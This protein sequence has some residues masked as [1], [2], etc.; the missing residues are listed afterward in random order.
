MKLLDRIFGRGAPA[1][2]TAES[3]PLPLIVVTTVFGALL[4]S[5]AGQAADPDVVRARLA[6]TLRDLE[7]API[8]PDEFDALARGLDDDGWGRLWLATVCARGDLDVLG[9][10]VAARGVPAVVRDGFIGFAKSSPLLTMELL[11]QSSL[12]VEEL[13]RRW[14]AALGARVDGETPEVSRAALERLDYGRLLAEVD[15]AKMSAE[16]RMA[17]LKKLQEEHDASRP[18]RGKW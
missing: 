10:L 3:P 1:E 17:Y 14:I 7:V 13:A 2:P 5:N 12:R 16:E 6:D 8:D 9:A 4:E 18:R 15:R 11:R